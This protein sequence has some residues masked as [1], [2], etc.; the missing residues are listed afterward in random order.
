MEIPII[1]KKIMTRMALYKNKNR[2]MIFLLNLETHMHEVSYFYGYLSRSEKERAKKFSTKELYDQYVI[3]HGILRLILSAYVGFPT[4][5]IEFF[6]NGYG[7]PFLKNSFVQFN[8]SHSNQ[9]AIYILSPYH[10]VGIDIEYH[11]HNLNIKEFLET[12]FTPYEKKLF[13]RIRE[14]NQKLDFFYQVWTAKEALIKANGKG[15]F[16]PL[17]EIEVKSIKSGLESCVLKD[18]IERKTWYFSQI[19]HISSYHISYASEY[20]ND[21]VMLIEKDINDY[22][23]NSYSELKKLG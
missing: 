7:K 2:L 5:A 17:T 10:H 22:T 11:D 3:S 19:E 18:K 8:I 13:E 21:E 6:Y 20:Q 23:F 9:K 15:L 14:D 1:S 4:Y 16:Y 12:V